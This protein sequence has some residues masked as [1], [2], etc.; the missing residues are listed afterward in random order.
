MSWASPGAE[1]LRQVADQL[2][3]LERA[4]SDRE[5]IRKAYSLEERIAAYATSP[6]RIAGL[7]PA[8]PVAFLCAEFRVHASLPIYA[9]GLGVLAG[10]TA[11]A[12]S[13]MGLPFVAVGFLYGQ[14]YFRQQFDIS[15][16][17]NEYWVPSDSAGLPG[18][19]V[20]LNGVD[21]LRIHVPIRGRE[22]TAQIWRFAIGRAPLFLLDTDVS[23]NEPVDRWITSRLYV[24]DRDTRLAQ[25]ALL[26]IG[27]VRALRAMGIDPGV[28]HID[29]G[30]AALAPLELAA[31]AVA[32]GATFADA[33]ESARAAC[34]AT[35]RTAPTAS[36][37]EGGRSFALP[38]R[39]A[40]A[41][42]APIDMSRFAPSREPDPA[43]RRILRAGGARLNP[44]ARSALRALR[45]S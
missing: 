44:R 40:G 6:R 37:P 43:P 19:L 29:E 20:T 2:A 17:Q 7:E 25:Y 31:E 39:P 28:F 42:A 24:G 27:G 35:T 30:H 5:L 1:D 15:G 8:H 4:A 13:D 33:L 9:G 36:S 10:D 16:W 21:P 14:G 34:C 32:G 38:A 3:A 26:G 23:D 18:A 22:V 12:A 45:T 11:K 41:P